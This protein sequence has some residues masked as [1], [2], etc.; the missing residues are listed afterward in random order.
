MK[1]ATFSKYSVMLVLT[2][3]LA[4]QSFA[5][6]A[7]KKQ[8]IAERIKPVGEVC[9]QGDSSCASTAVASSGGAK[10]GEE[11]YNASCTG[12]HSTGA[13]GAPKVGDSAAW[14]PRLAAGIDKVYDHA[15][16]GLNAM[17]PK[18]M[19]SSC[20]DDDIKATVDYMVKNSK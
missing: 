14:K 8:A 7:E 15:I 3:F 20:S 12:C 18:G 5:M 13:A 9:V 6:T 2:A 19:C 16:N 10:S 17:P 11:I 4:S 1:F